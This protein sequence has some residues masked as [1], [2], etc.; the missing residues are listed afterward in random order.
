MGKR[1]VHVIA[2]RKPVTFALLVLTTGV[3]ATLLY[4]LSGKAYAAD[5]HSM[6]EIAARFL[7]YGRGPLSRH[8]FLAFLMP[9]IANVL[10]FVPW[11]FLMFLAL[12]SPR[13][14]RKVSYAL[15]IL[16]AVIVAVALYVWQHFL[17]TRV[18]SLPDTI[19]NGAGAL[20]GAA[21]GHARKSMRIR[22]DF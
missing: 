9:I 10:L 14:P 16:A 13:R 22:F 18:T 7:G 2:V 8:A 20:A 1:H 12:D 5:H 17:P 3:M 19:A 4:L 15:T 6:L 11:G 21:L